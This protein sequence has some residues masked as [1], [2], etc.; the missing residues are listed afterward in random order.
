MQTDARRSRFPTSI[1]WVC[2]LGWSCFLAAQSVPIRPLPPWVTRLSDYG[3]RPQWSLDGKKVLFLTRG[4]GDVM[5]IDVESKQISPVTLHY[6]RP[7][8]WGYYRAYYLSNGD[9][10]LTGGPGRDAARL[11]IMDRRRTKPPKVFEDVLVGGSPAVSRHRPTIA[12]TGPRREQ[13]WTVQVVDR[14]GGPS[15]ARGRMIIDRGKVTVEGVEL[16]GPIEPRA[17]RPPDDGELIWCLYGT[18]EDGR[19]TAE[20]MGYDLETGQITDYSQTPQEYDEPEGIFP[21]GR[22]ILVGVGGR[23]PRTAGRVSFG[24]YRLELDA[25][26]RRLERLSQ[27]W[28]EA[29]LKATNAVVRDDGR[30]L[31]FQQSNSSASSGA[32]PGIYLV[33]LVRA[34]I[35]GP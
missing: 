15:L 2:V 8:D 24:L 5:E 34:G 29:G 23:R 7:R 33:D 12:F 26:Q 14:A 10:L 35:A 25:T 18:T 3:E 22:S 1:L 21:D 16:K 31:A 4:G 27:A 32:S 9:Y 17:F 19:A 13:I 11:Q 6:E 30:F 20:V 28:D